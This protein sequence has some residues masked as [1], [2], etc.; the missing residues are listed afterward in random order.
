M[1]QLKTGTTVGGY[2]VLTGQ[3]VAYLAQLVL[4]PPPVIITGTST[5]GSTLITMASTTG[6]LSGMQVNGV[7]SPLTTALACMLQGAN[8]TVTATAHGLANGDLVSF[9]TL[10]TTTG[11]AIYTP[12]Y[13]VNATTNIFQLALTAG[14]A[15]IDLG[16][17][18]SG[19]I[20]YRATITTVNTN[21]SVVL[22]RKMTG[23]GLANF[24]YR[25]FNTGLA[26][27]R[28]WAI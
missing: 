18:G 20:L 6:V 11:I 17:D 23:S 15:A 9:A 25:A 5:A 16:G 26:L 12:Y 10:V 4:A 19:T 24:E 2:Q 21:V 27:M 8:D 1:A 7:G 28:G 22:N 13:V 14:G 3:D